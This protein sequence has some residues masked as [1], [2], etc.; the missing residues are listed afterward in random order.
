MIVP[1]L[2]LAV[3][4]HAD[5]TPTSYAS[6]L[7]ARNGT[8]AEPFCKDFHIRLREVADGD[9]ASLR[10]LAALGGIEPE[11]MLANAFVRSGPRQWTF[12]GEPL[13]WTALQRTRLAICP[14]C[15]LA[16]IEAEPKLTPEAAVYGRASW[17][18]DVVRL[19]PVHRIPMA[20]ADQA[21]GARRR[22]LH[23][24]AQH[25]KQLVPNFAALANM[26]P[27][28][29]APLQTYV[30][31]RLA[32]YKGTALLD[33]MRLASVVRLCETAGAPKVIQGSRPTTSGA[34]P[35]AVATSRSPKARTL[36]ARCWRN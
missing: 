27:Q 25:A 1:K 19:C 18:L 36:S 2:R 21:L 11:R 10:T 32:G 26:P 5:E 9:E 3:P 22:L 28:E 15:A 13:D 35:A 31:R 14:A 30:L 17:L 24:F 4:F 29:P 8:R 34:P 23:D 12:R 20:Y 16:D 33:S 6:R 7:A